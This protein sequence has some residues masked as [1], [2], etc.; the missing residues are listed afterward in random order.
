MK[1]INIKGFP[2]Y[3]VPENRFKTCRFN[4]EFILKYDKNHAM[5][6]LILTNLLSKS[7]GRFP[8]EED[9]SYELERLYRSSDY[10]SL[11][12]IGTTQVISFETKHINPKFL[13]EDVNLLK[14]N[15]DFLADM[16][17]NP[18]L[19]EE[20]LQKE[21]DL[22]ITT[23]KNSKS[24]K[25]KMSGAYFINALMK[26]EP[27]Y[28]YV[29]NLEKEIK[30]V[31]LEDLYNELELIKSSDCMA[32]CLG[33]FDEESLVRVLNTMPFEK[34]HSFTNDGTYFTR[35]SI[36]HHPRKVKY[37]EDSFKTNN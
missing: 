10:C 30:K 27:T 12:T 16:L 31:T 4:L 18:S 33:E 21:K 7:S 29:I 34:L 19:T 15:L 24:N 2:V 25:V 3:V 11:T 5:T 6:R 9:F 23:I 14:E 32:C 28:E 13:H 36:F 20:K 26:H 17:Y 1:I 37:I 22:L 35:T 8:N